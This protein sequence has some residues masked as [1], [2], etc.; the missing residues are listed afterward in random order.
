ML[1]L[2]ATTETNSKNN[3]QLALPGS[4]NNNNQMALEYKPPS[5]AA[6]GYK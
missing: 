3:K 2:N 6:I 4:Q 5:Q 1:Q